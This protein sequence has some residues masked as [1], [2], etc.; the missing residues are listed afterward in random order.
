MFPTF[1]S[2]TY[3]YFMTYQVKVHPKKVYEAVTHEF[4]LTDENGKD[5]ML[6]K[7]EDWNEGGYYIFENDRWVDFQPDEE[8]DDFITYDLDF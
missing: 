3:F 8:L 1:V 7:W 2:G 5:L 6:R 4:T